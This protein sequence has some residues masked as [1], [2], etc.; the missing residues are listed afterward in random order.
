MDLVAIMS[1]PVAGVANGTIVVTLPG[2]PKGA[3]ENLEAI[4]K[5][6]P[7]ACLQATGMNSR[8]LHAGGVKKL[9]QDA[10]VASTVGQANHSQAH[11]HAHGH[12]IPRAHTQPQDRPKSNDPVAGPSRRYRESPYPMLSVQDAIATI[13]QHT[14]K[15][16]EITI[17]VTADLVDYIIAEDVPAKE[18]VPAFRASI[19]DGYAIVITEDGSSK[20]V[21]P[22]A[23]VSHASSDTVPPLQVGRIAR[24]TTG[25]PLPEGAT[26]VVMVEDTILKSTTSDGTEEKE[27]E[28]LT[29][30]VKVNENVR[31]V[32]SDI[33][34]DSIILRRGD[35]IGPGELGLLAS[36]GIAM[37]KAFRRPIIAVLSTGDEIVQHDRLESLKLG[38]VRDCNRPATSSVLQS[39]GYSTIDCG[40][41]SDRYVSLVLVIQ[42]DREVLET[43]K[44]VSEMLCVAVTSLLLQEVFLWENSIY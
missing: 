26:S 40:I 5:L 2:S 12:A 33:E 36:V 29:D 43:S 32:G 30:A 35:K 4:I 18:A 38:E 8:T 20:G 24:I 17:P 34:Q 44:P 1:R 22:V 21:F 13:L 27:V 7:H 28:I 25:A 15:A 14:P 19:V 11:H 16:K 37:V 41:A 9:E 31:E 42:A 3:K 23:S 10:G 39:A 6:L